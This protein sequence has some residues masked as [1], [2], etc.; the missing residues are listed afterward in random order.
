MR[1]A[2]PRGFPLQAI[3]TSVGQAQL[4]LPQ[5]GGAACLPD[6]L[7]FNCLVFGCSLFEGYARINEL[8]VLPVKFSACQIFQSENCRD[9]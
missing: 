1:P 8:V 4:G 3:Q 5:T 6:P 7:K 9:T 2:G